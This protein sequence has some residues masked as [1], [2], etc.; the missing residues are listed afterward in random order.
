M[1][2]VAAAGGVAASKYMAYNFP[3]P[4][5]LVTKTV[6]LR[7]GTSGVNTSIRGTYIV[8]A[9]TA[10][11]TAMVK[12]FNVA[13][14]LVREFS[15]SVTGSQYNYIEWDGRNDSGGDVASGVYFA[16]ID[17]PGAPKKEPVKMVLVK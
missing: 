5:N 7:T 9:P 15:T 17:A 6:T 4:F 10:S 13:G 14:D 2:G 16:V 11:G 12:I 3:N 1:V 8:V